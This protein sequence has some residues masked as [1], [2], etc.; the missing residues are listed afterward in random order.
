VTFKDHLKLGCTHAHSGPLN[1][2]LNTTGGRRSIV[3]AKAVQ[4][5]SF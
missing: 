5:K 2:R 4:L 3:A 1:I